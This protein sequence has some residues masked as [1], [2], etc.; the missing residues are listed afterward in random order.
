MY[1]NYFLAEVFDVSRIAVEGAAVACCSS[2]FSTSGST[3][4]TRSRLFLTPRSLSLSR[5][6]SLA[7]VSFSPPRLLFLLVPIPR[8]E[9]QMAGID[10]NPESRSPGKTYSADTYLPT[11]LPTYLS[12]SLSTCTYPTYHHPLT[13]TEPATFRP[14]HSVQVNAFPLDE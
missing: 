4:G 7:A 11:Y 6:L 3:S 1:R 14:I 13:Y 8:F 12:R 5:L 2:D 10:L 9:A